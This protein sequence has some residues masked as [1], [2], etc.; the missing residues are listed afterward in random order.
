MKEKEIIKTKVIVHF[1]NPFRKT[2]N[3]VVYEMYFKEN[4]VIFSCNGKLYVIPLDRILYI[5]RSS[6]AHNGKT[7]DKNGIEW[8]S[9]YKDF[10]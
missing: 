1:N 3:I 4:H 9:E 8:Q 2:L 7:I 5:E 6:L 10:K